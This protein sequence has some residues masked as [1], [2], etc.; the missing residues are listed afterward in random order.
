LARE[1]I[2]DVTTKKKG[3][4][5]GLQKA[6][7]RP[8][9]LGKRN[10]QKESSLF[11]VPGGSPSRTGAKGGF[12]RKNPKT[13]SGSSSQT[14]RGGGGLASQLRR[15]RGRGKTGPRGKSQISAGGK[16]QDIMKS[17]GNPPGRRGKR[18]KKGNLTKKESRPLCERLG[19]EVAG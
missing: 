13:E 9:G 2:R 16:S 11:R 12:K 1:Q 4:W 7:I 8:M 14:Q 18:K 10:R 17:K 6:R 3:N 15:L 19:E 5:G